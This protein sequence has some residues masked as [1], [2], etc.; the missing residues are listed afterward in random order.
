MKFE[1]RVCCICNEHKKFLAQINAGKKLYC[2]QCQAQITKEYGSDYWKECSFEECLEAI[3]TRKKGDNR[4][5]NMFNNIRDTLKQ[6]DD[7]EI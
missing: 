2:M 6:I 7:E 1:D 4:P 3:P 5:R